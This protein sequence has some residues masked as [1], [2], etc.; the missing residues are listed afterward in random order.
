MFCYNCGYKTDSTFCPECGTKMIDSDSKI[1]KSWRQESDF[2]TIVKHPDV[3]ELISN[4]STV[5]NKKIDSKYLLD[6]FDLVFGTFTG[7]S[8]NLITEI[9]LPIYSKLGIKLGKK[10]ESVFFEPINEVFVKTLCSISSNKKLEFKEF[11]QAQDGLFIISEIKPD[12]LSFR[13]NLT[14]EIQKN[15]NVKLKI[16]AITKGQLF[17]FGKS[18]KI[19][20]RV[21]SD[22]KTIE[23]E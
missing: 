12:F 18:K 9:V 11:Y 21:L 22:L 23:L 7:V 3:L 17:D 20:S 2:K 13:G 6:K 15:E 1:I 8:T 16:N 14:I 4:Y 5:S 19:I 10:K